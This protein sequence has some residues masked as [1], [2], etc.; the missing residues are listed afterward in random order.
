MNS[1]AEPH[2]SLPQKTRNL[3]ADLNPPSL[4]LACLV[5]L[6]AC[7]LAYSNSLQNGFMLD[8]HLILFGEQGVEQYNSFLDVFT[9][10][11]G[12][13]YRPVGH[14][15]LAVSYSLFG[16]QVAGY[17]LGNLGLFFLICM[18]FFVIT[19]LLFA[20]RRLSLLAAV[21]YALHPINGM[22]VNY[23]TASILSTY[24][25][26]LEFSF[27]LFILW[28]K[29]GKQSLYVLSLLCFA[30]A[31]LSH[32]MSLMFPVY[33]LCLLHFLKNFTL[34]RSLWTCL[35][36]FS[37]SSV[38][39][40]IRLRFVSL[41]GAFT[42]PAD[43]P[44][45]ALRSYVATILDLS[46]WYVSKLVSQRDIIFL[47]SS[48]LATDDLNLKFILAAGVL[49]G[50]LYLI[51]IR[52]GKGLNAF[53][54]AIFVAG[55][56][57]ISFA[58]FMY[59]PYVDPIIEPHWFY[60]SS[61]GLF[62]ML[63]N[64]LV[65]LAEKTRLA[66]GGLLIS[67][68]LVT[69]ILAAREANT[70]WKD[71]ETYCRYWLSLN[72]LNLTPYYGLGKSRLDQ[73]DCAQAIEL[74]EEGIAVGNYSSEQIATDLGNAYAC[75]GHDEL[76]ATSYQSALQMNPRYSLAHHHQAL[77]FLK[78]GAGWEA[79]VAF[80]NALRINPQSE[81]SY[82]YLL[83]VRAELEGNIDEA[84]DRYRKISVLYPSDE[85]SRKKLIALSDQQEE[86][87]RSEP[88]GQ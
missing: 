82:E 86:Q 6:V 79:L 20:N 49:I 50:I 68:L 13:F 67:S 19:E 15:V 10:K 75:L 44:T 21:L 61:F 14:L 24:I 16:S 47:W 12:S 39:F 53:S 77:L 37:M 72:P 35:P 52:W 73:G 65:S 18:M 36:F 29:N 66:L 30:M 71:Q 27:A 45:P 83:A 43:T 59:L 17:H 76:A 11:L 69:G 70:N 84:M 23:V 5:V 31:L 62:L 64:L 28:L 51:F 41:G 8:D 54:L 32:E 22:L 7:V 81:S 78:Y 26:T 87:A 58:S 33:L 3:L 55:L 2:L 4:P 48:E 63:S 25:L 88:S 38:Y 46:Y 42:L 57:P 56:A 85:L 1:S 60:F 9:E 80:S 34:K 74:F 40:L